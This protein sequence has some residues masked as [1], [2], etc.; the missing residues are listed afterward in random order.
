ML[1]PNSF[2]RYALPAQRVNLQA[3]LPLRSTQSL[4]SPRSRTI[5]NS[6]ATQ[7]A[8]GL[9]FGYR[10]PSL[11]VLPNGHP[12]RPI[13]IYG[14]FSFSSAFNSAFKLLESITS[15]PSSPRIKVLQPL[16]E[17]SWR[18]TC[19]KMRDVHDVICPS[20]TTTCSLHTVLEEK[21]GFGTIA[22]TSLKI[23]GAISCSI[24]FEVPKASTAVTLSR[25]PG[26]V[27]RYRQLSIDRATHPHCA[28]DFPRVFSFY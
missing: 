12:I 24:R 27:L 10:D 20:G 3:S 4:S 1:R 18:S 19:R 7:C 17:V 21:F 23:A 28:L 8:C 22:A 13:S 15:P 16:K 5:L 14:A 26:N 9:H 25:S 6:A 2:V 11:N